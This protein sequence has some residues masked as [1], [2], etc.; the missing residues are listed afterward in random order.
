MVT[1]VLKIEVKKPLNLEKPVFYQAMR[2]V[3][4]QCWKL[5]N[6]GIRMRWDYQGF[7]FAYKER[8]GDYYLKQ[9]KKLPNG[10]KTINYDILNELKED[11]SALAGNCKDAMIRMIDQKWKNDLKDILCG[12]KSI[13]SFNRTLPIELHNKQFMDSKKN[14]RIYK[15]GKLYSTIINMVNKE[16]AKELGLSDGNFHLEL[17]VKD[18][19]QKVIV[20]GVINGE[21][22]L[23]MSKMQYD[24]KK[25]KWFLLLTYSFEAQKKELDSNRILGIDLGINIPA[26]LAISDSTHYRQAIGNAEEI[27]MFEKQVM[28]R[29]NRLQKSRVWAGDGSVGHGRKTRLKPLEKIGN[30]ISNYKKTKNHCWS[31]EIVNIAL[32]E[33]C[34]VIQ[35]EDLSGIAEN[36]TFLKTWTYFQLQTMIENKASEHGIKV[37]K[38]EPAH[39][40]ARCNKCGHIH[41]KHNKNEWRPSQEEFKCQNCNYKVNAD[42]NAARN[43]AMKDIDKIIKKQLELQKKS[44][45]HAMKYIAE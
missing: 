19:Y 27:K 6:K 1:K 16:Y 17:I 30:K 42:V 7:D 36:E 28:Q 26:M 29:K 9:N 20:D 4:Y 35:M 15:E 21:Y 45:Q 37:V 44:S 31:R 22:K 24:D 10:Y 25:K 32:R 23:S 14:V 41:M 13:P 11:A 5:A 3:Q 38:I 39:T 33:Q 43:I 40:S 12:N 8:F 2:D 34:G 18:H